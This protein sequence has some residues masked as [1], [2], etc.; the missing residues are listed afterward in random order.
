MIPVM[1]PTTIK[2]FVVS[3]DAHKRMKCHVCRQPLRE[4]EAA[5]AVVDSL[6]V[7]HAHDGECPKPTPHSWGPDTFIQGSR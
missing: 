1:S 7:D 3:Q 2:R 4:G 6:G 5:I